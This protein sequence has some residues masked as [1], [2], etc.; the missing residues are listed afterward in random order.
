MTSSLHQLSQQIQICTLNKSRG[1]QAL[2]GSDPKKHSP[3]TYG[4][5][6]ASK[7]AV[8]SK[9]HGLEFGH[10]STGNNFQSEVLRRNE[11]FALTYVDRI[12]FP[13]Y[14]CSTSAK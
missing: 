6:S 5:G 11:V 3:G 8:V 12:F 9:V 4:T 7:L 2:H 10:F 13:S 14:N 1:Y